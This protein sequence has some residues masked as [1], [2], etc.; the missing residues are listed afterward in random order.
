MDQ[1]I[2]HLPVLRFNSN[3]TTNHA[4]NENQLNYVV[5]ME[6]PVQK[7]LIHME[8]TGM[9][10]DRNA[11]EMLSEQISDYIGELETEI[12]RLNG[13]R[14]SVN[15]S[16]A[17]AQALQI[18]KKNGLMSAKCTRAQLL[19]SKHPMAQLILEHRSLHAIL[20]KS[21]QPLIKK[22]TDKNR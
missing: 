7:S 16:R 5:E 13:K 3:N 10:L 4:S 11:L 22:T 14:F 1:F 18:R 8:Q 21:I 2:R 15:S 9:A 19:Q 17:V 12:F 6:M 20:S